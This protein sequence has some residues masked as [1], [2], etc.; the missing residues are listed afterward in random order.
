MDRKLSV[1]G[2]ERYACAR[3]LIVQLREIHRYLRISVKRK[4]EKNTQNKSE[5]GEMNDITWCLLCRR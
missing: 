2:D 1:V 3:Q 5:N 4:T